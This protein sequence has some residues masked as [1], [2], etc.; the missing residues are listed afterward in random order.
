MLE[1]REYSASI[2]IN[3]PDKGED[4]LFAVGGIGEYDGLSSSE[5]IIPGQVNELTHTFNS[6]YL[7]LL[8]LFCTSCLFF[9]C[10]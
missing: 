8:C 4:S 5:Y 9:S 10:T 2:V 1:G 6:T 3:L 7:H